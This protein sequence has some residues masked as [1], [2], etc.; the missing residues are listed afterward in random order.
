MYLKHRATSVHSSYR[1]H[2]LGFQYVTHLFIANCSQEL[3]CN[4]NA[5]NIDLKDLSNMCSN[6][7]NLLSGD[8]IA[9]IEILRGR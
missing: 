9:P 4:Q 8:S 1:I 6:H 3:Q 5:M 2:S 7:L